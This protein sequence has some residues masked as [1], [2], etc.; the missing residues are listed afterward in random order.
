[1]DDFDGQWWLQ[2]DVSE[3]KFP[4][5]SEFMCIRDLG[6]LC[7]NTANAVLHQLHGIGSSSNIFDPN[8]P[9]TK[10][11]PRG[12][13]NQSARSDPSGFEHLEGAQCMHMKSQ[14]SLIFRRFAY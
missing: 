4:K 14:T 7:G 5:E 1:M 13:L 8:I 2:V 9:C 10:G 12:A 11:R 6:T 3:E